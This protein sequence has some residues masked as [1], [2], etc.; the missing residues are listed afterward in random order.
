MGRWLG[1]GRESDYTM[2]NQW[3]VLV[4]VE[5]RGEKQSKREER[6]LGV[7]RVITRCVIND[8]DGRR[9]A[10]GGGKESDYTMCNQWWVLGTVVR[11][12]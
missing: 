12:G 9:E 10:R 4:K 3:W 11:W 7:R 5:K 6:S 8:D 2:C 1:G